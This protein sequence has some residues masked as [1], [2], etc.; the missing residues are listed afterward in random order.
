M[1]TINLIWLPL[2]I[3]GIVILIWLILKAVDKDLAF[4]WTFLVIVVF[5]INVGIYIITGIVW[6]AQHLTITI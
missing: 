1:I 2:I 5:M 4:L 6:V 3:L